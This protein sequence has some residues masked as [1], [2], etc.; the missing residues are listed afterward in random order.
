MTWYSITICC[1]TYTHVLIF[2]WA[3]HFNKQRVSGYLSLEL[4]V[5]GSLLDG[6]SEA[7]ATAPPC[8]LGEGRGGEGR[9]GEG[10]GGEGRGGE[11]RGGEG[12][13]GEGREG[14]E[15]EDEWLQYLSGL[16]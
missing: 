8:A 16:D 11:G 1:D 10:R 9:G 14:G 3:P 13:G 4:C 7:V 2:I 12:R 6:E 15:G 5:A